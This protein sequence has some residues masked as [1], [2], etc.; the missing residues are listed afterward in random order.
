MRKTRISKGVIT[1][2][3][4]FFGLFVF[5]LF[6]YYTSKIALDDIFASFGTVTF[7]GYT[8]TLGA[9]LAVGASTIDIGGILRIFTPEQG[10]HEPEWVQTAYIF[11]ILSSLINAC[12][13][14]W[15]VRLGLLNPIRMPPELY[16]KEP[17]IAVMVALFVW[18]IRYGLVRNVGTTG[19]AFIN[20]QLPTLLGSGGASKSSYNNFSTQKSSKKY[21][22]SGRFK[23]V[24][25]LFGKKQPR[26][27]TLPTTP[28][29]GGQ[30]QFK[31]PHLNSNLGSS[32]PIQ[33]NMKADNGPG[34]TSK[35]A[36]PMSDDESDYK[37]NVGKWSFD[38]FVAAV[39]K[40]PRLLKIDKN[41]VAELAG[42]SLKTIY[43]WSDKVQETL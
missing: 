13:T 24:K 6:N 11:W 22:D 36:P 7:L 9:L 32:K 21:D 39:K 14:W 25:K 40:N 18:A 43:R 23:T 42:V 29:F 15:V 28:A 2:A 1:L 37:A 27:S 34:L 12:L 4:L 5:E 30:Q 41:K 19:D 8:T 35:P 16:G 26:S 17:I 10:K 38:N 31:M 33:L 20:V 3:L